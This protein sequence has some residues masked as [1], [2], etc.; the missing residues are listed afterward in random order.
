MLRLLLGKGGPYTVFS[1]RTE[2]LVL[3]QTGYEWRFPELGT[4]LDDL[5]SKHSGA[6]NE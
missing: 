1:Q 5:L 2:A 3:D 6:A 4:A